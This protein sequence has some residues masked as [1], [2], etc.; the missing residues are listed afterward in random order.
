MAGP[1]PDPNRRRRN[2]PTISTTHLPAGGRP[3]PPPRVPAP[4]RLG[5]AGKAWWR[6]AWAT[7]QAA[8]WDPGSLQVIA[9]RASLEDDI[10]ALAD[11]RGLDFSELLDTDDQG[12]V[13]AVVRRLAAL[14]TGRIG[15]AK[16]MRELDRA[17][18]LT[19]KA[20]AE[21]RWTI[22]ADEVAEARQ[23]R[24]PRRL[25]AVDPS[26]VAGG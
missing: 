17:L 1:L 25:K 26:A 23:A 22:A 10:A 24:A 19:P 2:A 11:V 6:W 5:K 13:T 14:A 15:I 9:R 3:G 18:G 21:L 20:M 8:A 16:E 7:P 4:A 12:R